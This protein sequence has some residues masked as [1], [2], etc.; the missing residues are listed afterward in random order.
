MVG[1]G[2]VVA[3][4]YRIR[5]PQT[6][7]LTAISKIR[8]PES[9]PAT[10]SSRGMA[11]PPSVSFSSRIANTPGPRHRTRGSYAQR[12][13]GRLQSARCGCSA[14]RLAAHSWQMAGPSRHA[15]AW[16]V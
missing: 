13:P 2:F 5:T 9:S 7:R 3:T 15:C 10:L 12:A 11:V 14:R 6:P 8:T 4:R 1:M 16:C